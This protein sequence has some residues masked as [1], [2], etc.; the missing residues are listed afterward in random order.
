[1]DIDDSDELIEQGLKSQRYWLKEGKQSMIRLIN[2]AFKEG[3]QAC[4]RIND[5]LEDEETERVCKNCNK[6]FMA[7]SPEP[8]ETRAYWEWDLG[9]CSCCFRDLGLSKTY[10]EIK[11]RH[12]E[13]ME[14]LEET[15]FALIGKAKQ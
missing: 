10:Y 13:E 4:K 15:A 14:K 6:K 8:L 12:S 5:E 2:R 7:A 1:M 11:E 9:I 3:F